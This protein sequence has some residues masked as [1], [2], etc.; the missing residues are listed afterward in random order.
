MCIGPY[1]FIIREYIDSCYIKHLQ[2][3]FYTKTINVLPDD[4]PVKS[5]SVGV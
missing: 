5:E 2:L 4:G 3:L 1:W